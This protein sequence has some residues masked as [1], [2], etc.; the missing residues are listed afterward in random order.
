MHFFLI[1]KRKQQTY[2]MILR[3]V[4]PMLAGYGAFKAPQKVET[5]FVSSLLYPVICSG[6]T[7]FPKLRE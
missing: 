1:L 4:P 3:Y 6:R 7:D 2:P 5:G